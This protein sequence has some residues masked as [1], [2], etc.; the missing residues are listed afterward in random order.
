MVRSGAMNGADDINSVA[1]VMAI[2]DPDC[3]LLQAQLQSLIA[4]RGVGLTLFAVIDG[5]GAISPEG[6]RLLKAHGARIIAS[7]V[8][9]GIRTAFFAGLAAALAGDAGGARYFA[10]CDQDDVWHAEKLAV[11]IAALKETGARLVHCDARVVDE[12]GRE[13]AA[14]LHRYERREPADTL[15]DHVLINYVTG[16][17]SVFTRETARTALALSR[18]LDSETLHDHITAVAAAATGEVR[19]LDRRLVDYVQHGGNSLGAIARRKNRWR[20][21]L[22]LKHIRAYRKTS[23]RLFRERRALVRHL[24]R[25]GLAPD[26]LCRMFPADGVPVPARLYLR[27]LLKFAANGKTRRLKI[28]LYMMGA[29]WRPGIRA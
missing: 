6:L 1:V 26:D 2:R 27:E 25:E 9:L 10:Y 17:T 11:S 21:V 8:H 20:D 7:D 19:F 4:Q 12:A 29:A 24:Q 23:L 18:D 3:Q 22:G 13:I 16:M 5:D 14:S 15:L 28:W